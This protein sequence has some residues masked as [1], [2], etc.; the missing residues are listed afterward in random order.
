[1]DQH[2]QA[3]GAQSRDRVGGL[4]E[5]QVQVGVVVSDLVI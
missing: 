5:H 3:L 4:G 2:G 1:V